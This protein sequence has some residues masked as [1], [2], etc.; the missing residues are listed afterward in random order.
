MEF[1]KELDNLLADRKEN[2]PEKSYTTTLFDGGLD[3]ILRKVGEETG[4]VII[5]AKNDDDDELKNEVSDLLFHVMV[6]LKE[7]NLSLEDVVAVLK[8]RHKK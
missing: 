8:S 7:K 5:A 1:L 2:R 6:L 4:E 3:R